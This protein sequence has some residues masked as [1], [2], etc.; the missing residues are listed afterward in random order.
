MG[1]SP[2]V[3]CGVWVGFDSRQSLGDKET[4]ARAALPIWMTFMREAIKGKDDERFSSDVGSSASLAKA[5][6]VAA[7]AV[8]QA[9]K[10]APAVAVKPAP[11]VT[12]KPP[13]KPLAQAPA[14]QKPAATAPPAKAVVKPALPMTQPSASVPKPQPPVRKAFPQ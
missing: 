14:P 13:E 10:P 7:P 5:E 4:G 6:V 2:S 12:G 3:T 1:F 11:A 9:P 8:V